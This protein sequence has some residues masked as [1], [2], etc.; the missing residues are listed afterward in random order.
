MASLKD[1]AVECQV[2]VATVSKALNGH[3]D[4]SEETKTLV[5]QKAEE[6]GYRPNLFARTLKTKRSYNIGVLFI[7]EAHNGLT[8]D[9]FAAVLDG[10]KVAVEEKGYDLTFLNC[11]KNGKDRMTYLEHARYRGFDG[12]IIACVDFTDPEVLELAQSEIPLVTI[13][14]TFNNRLAVLSDNVKGMESLLAYAY[15]KGHRQIAYVHGE[16]TDVTKNRLSGFYRMAEA[17]GLEIPDEYVIEEHYRDMEG[18]AEATRHLLDL[19][20]PPTCILYPDDF[21]AFGGVSEIRKRG[22][23]IPEDISVIGYDGNRL[24]RHTIPSLT[25]LWQDT[26]HIGQYAAEKL[27]QLIE[28]PKT[29][30]RDITVVK[31][32]VFEGQTI[33]DLNQGN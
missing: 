5:R 17:L 22:L 9:Y 32:H 3:S 21:A 28:N 1:I 14:H 24:A 4:I 16:D 10:F 23:S 7:D 19:H 13:D 6:I 31:G 27:I 20:N 15:A 2:S 26:G 30:L 8:H 25:T 33:R 29:A 11:N 12:V 18:A